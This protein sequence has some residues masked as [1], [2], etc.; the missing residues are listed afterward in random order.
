MY[1]GDDQLLNGFNKT[2]ILHGLR[3]QVHG[4]GPKH[5]FLPPNLKRHAYTTIYTRDREVPASES[6]SG[7]RNF[8]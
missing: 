6:L 8:W 7:T 5:R 4:R 2:T 1:P 3:G